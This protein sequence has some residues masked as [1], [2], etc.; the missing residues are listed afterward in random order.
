MKRT[1]AWLLLL[2]SAWPP[3][4][5]GAHSRFNAAAR[6]IDGDTIAADFRLLGIDAFERRQLCARAG[7]CWPCGKAAQDLAAHL[8]NGSNA[9][10]SL[11]RASSYGRPL[12]TVTIDGRDLGER[13]VRAGLAVP[14]PRYLKSDPERAG[15]YARAFAAAKRE[16]AGAMSGRWIEP[17]HWRRGKRLACE[18]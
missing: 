6:A 18:K 1:A 3:T 4:A 11:S 12:A 15:L 2:L 9:Q 16:R 17:A 13:L 14:Q 7:A 8:L 10:I 5:A